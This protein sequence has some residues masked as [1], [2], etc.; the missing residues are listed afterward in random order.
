[1]ADELDDADLDRL[2]E[3]IDAKDINELLESWLDGSQKKVVVYAWSDV[4]TLVRRLINL[5]GWEADL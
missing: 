1:M 3:F 4:S 2:A 5:V